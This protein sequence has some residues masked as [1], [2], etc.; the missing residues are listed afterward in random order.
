MCS[1]EPAVRNPPS[2]PFSAAAVCDRSTPTVD[3]NVKIVWIKHQ[4]LSYINTCDVLCFFH[5]TH[6]RNLLDI[7]QH[8]EN[9]N[10]ITTPPSSTSSTGPHHVAGPRCTA[11]DSCSVGGFDPSSVITA[12]L[13]FAVLYCAVHM[14]ER[15]AARL[16]FETPVRTV[17]DI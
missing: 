8:A 1:S 10:N 16:Y 6:P 12:S 7:R 3:G 9:T 5:E 17:Q 15:C 14:C 4:Y 11:V 2:T 13:S